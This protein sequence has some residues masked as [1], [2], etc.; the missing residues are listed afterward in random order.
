MFTG[1]ISHMGQI[2]A[3]DDI[4]GGAMF[5][6]GVPVGFLSDVVLGDSIAVNG[7]CLTV[8]ELDG[9]CYRVEVSHET[10]AKT[11][12]STWQI[13]SRVNLEKAMRL[14]DR[15]GG[16]LVAGHVDGVGVVADL[17]RLDSG[18]QV[19]VTLSQDLMRYTAPKG[20][21][22]LDGVSLTTNAVD[23]ARAQV[24]LTIIEHTRRHTT[25]KYWQV[26]RRVNVEVDL[27]ARYMAQL[28]DTR[29]WLEIK[30]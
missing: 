14:S 2:S 13:G 18:W 7:A 12:A 16:H 26:G 6:I 23:M 28:M 22:T 29:A 21:I 10:M 3:R 8:A 30:E 25:I 27:L 24:H 20:S 4:D 17:V 15:L 1:I 19:A 9:A 5:W 11:T